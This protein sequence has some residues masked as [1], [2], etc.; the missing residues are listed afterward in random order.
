METESNGEP[1]R[2]S[3][4]GA[5][6]LTQ[7]IPGTAK[8]LNVRDP[9]DSDASLDAGARY[10]SQLLR[11]FRDIHLAVAAYNAGPGNVVGRAIPHNGETERY[12]VKVMTRYAQL[13]PAELR[14]SVRARN[15]RPRPPTS[16]SFRP[17]AHGP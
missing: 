1:H 14:A 12:V 17:S 5:M 4:A 9:F 11:E 2:I 7:L 13:A 10:L 6:G 16:R 8:M 3:P 15:A